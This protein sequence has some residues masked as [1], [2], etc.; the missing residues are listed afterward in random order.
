MIFL[1]TKLSQILS[2]IKDYIKI[3]KQLKNYKDFKIKKLFPIFTD[4]EQSAGNASG[5]YFHQDLYVARQICQESPTKHLDIWSRIDGFVAHVASYRDI[6][7]LDIRPISNK[8]KWIRFVQ[9]DLMNLP[10]EYV[11]YTDSLSCL[12]TIEHF[13]LW[14]YWDPIDVEGHIK[15]LD[16]MYKILQKWWVFYLSTPI[17]PQR[18]EFNAHRV[19]DI[20][21]LLSYFWDKYELMSFSYVDDKGDFHEDIDLSDKLIKN[22]CNCRYGCGIFILQKK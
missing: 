22:N 4:K 2:V 10:K 7:V 8:I 1:P 19:F 9:S 20:Q 18:I 14:R 16:N 15:W 3:K 17:W 13:G 12:H 21:Y 6:E 11:N 5:H